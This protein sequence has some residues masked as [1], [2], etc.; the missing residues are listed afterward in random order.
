MSKEWNKAQWLD[1]QKSVIREE[2]AELKHEKGN[3]SPLK[4]D[5]QVVGE[6]ARE[7]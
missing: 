7:Q 1:W 2:L 4:H 5:I 6:H 3:N